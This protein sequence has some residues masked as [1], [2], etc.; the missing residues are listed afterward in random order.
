MSLLSKNDHGFRRGYE[1]DINKSRLQ[2]ARS[3]GA[4]STVNVT[5][6]SP[7]EAAA[8]VGAAGGAP[9]AAIECSGADS[10]LLTAIHAAESGCIIATVG[11]GSVE[12]SLPVSLITTKEL[13]IR[14]I[15]RYANCYEAALQ[16]VSSGAVTAQQMVSHRYQLE[17]VE[18]AFQAARSGEPVKVMIKVGTRQTPGGVQDTRWCTGHQVVY[19]TP[20]TGRDGALGSNKRA[21]YGGWSQKQDQRSCSS[22]VAAS[23][24]GRIFRTVYLRNH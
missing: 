20:G 15:F 4:D 13:E 6:L 2:S 5:G 17:D 3:L 22:W 24:G 21:R 1:E 12:P 18:E 23:R 16:L 11:R 14:G 9:T 10:S 7:E 8:A 19:R